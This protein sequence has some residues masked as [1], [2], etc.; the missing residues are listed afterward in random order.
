MEP[1]LQKKNSTIEIMNIEF[2]ISP[3]PVGLDFS[4]VTFIPFHSHKTNFISSV[5]LITSLKP[6]NVIL[7]NTD[8]RRENGE[9]LS[10]RYHSI[11]K[12]RKLEN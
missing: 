5:Q 6:D 4:R 2:K 8:S 9:T 3:A 1:V 12:S 11:F 10:S 7:I